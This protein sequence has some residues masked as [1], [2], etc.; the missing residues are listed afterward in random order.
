M[1]KDKQNFQIKELG[2]LT[3]RE[4]VKICRMNNISCKKCLLNKHGIPCSHVTY[5]ENLEKQ[6]K[7][8][9]KVRVPYAKIH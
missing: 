4:Y 8:T 1:P 9:K 2:D 3:L 7:L 6:G 5:I